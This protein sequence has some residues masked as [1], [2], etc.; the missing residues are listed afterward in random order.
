M[1]TSK[2]AR[3]FRSLCLGFCVLL[4]AVYAQSAAADPQ[5]ENISLY[6][7]LD[8]MERA[9]T[10]SGYS[11]AQM[12]KCLLPYISTVCD[13]W[14]SIPSLLR[15]EYRAMF[16]R[17]DDP[18]SWWYKEGLPRVLK[19]PHFVFHYTTTGPDA[20][21][22]RDISPHNGVPDFVEVCAESYEKSYRI[23]ISEMGYRAPYDDFWLDDNGGDE[24][25][26]V[27]MFS[28]PWLGFTM[29]EF[30]AAVQSTT[31]VAP[32]YF[33][34]N[35]RTYELLGD[36]EGKRYAETTCAH[37]FFHAVQFRYNYNMYRWYMETCSTWIERIVYDG[38]ELGETD[39]NNYYNNQLT[40]WFRYP[41]WSL[42]LFN[43][44]HEYGDVIW[45]IFLTERY[46]VDIVKDF[47]EDMSEG[48][49]RELANFYDVFE[50]RGTTLGV[51]FKEF[52]LWNYFTRD[53]HDDRFYSHGAEYPQVSIH[54]DNVHQQYPVRVDLDSEQSPEEL[55]SR[56]IR[57]LPEPG[58]DTLSIKVD[59]SDVPGGDDVQRLSIWGTRGWGAK[60]VIHRKGRSPKPDEIFLFQMSQEGQRNFA[61][62]GTEIQEVVLIL[63]N[64]HPDLDIQSVSYCAGQ[65]PQGRLSEPKLTS[66]DE[67]EIY[68]SWELLD[69]SGIKE[70]AVVRKRFAP[71][72]YDQDNSPIR[73]EEV[74]S[75]SD[76]DA[77]G[78]PDPNIDIAGRV[79]ATDTM[80]VDNPTYFDSVR[81]Y[82]AVVPLS[83]YGIMGTPAIAVSGI[84]PAAPPP[85][86]VIT[87]QSLAP[88]AWSVSMYASQ[89][90]N[91]MPEL[92]SVTPDGRRIRIKL[93]RADES[94]QL[95]QGEF[96][97]SPFPPT[98]IYTYIVSVKA[99]SGNNVH[100][101]ITE[102]GQFLYTGDSD[103]QEVIC[104]PNPFNPH[105]DGELKFYSSGFEISKIRIFAISGE[106]VIELSGDRWDGKNEGKETVAS[107]IYIYLAEG[108]GVE[109]TGK[110]AV[111]R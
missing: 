6:A 1:I 60:L 51:A 82:Y 64:L 25:Y 57:F 101:V 31:V 16:Q 103:K 50:S 10:H 92:V 7:A 70:V 32:M 35:S 47:F 110:I 44:W 38:D 28:G 84:T 78:I 65:Q 67:G 76:N 15:D 42:T 26:D 105:I 80:F 86:V 73:E 68:V 41:D 77:N 45:N 62:F 29:P 11:S 46:D 75:A 90:L 22:S 3:N 107:G 40:Y 18:Q 55:G 66:G 8:M 95:W 94:Y 30:P 17:P 98:G 34:M 49:Y 85:T 81:Y 54:P 12:E 111:T 20:V 4:V 104:A 108:D 88:G 74:Y 36:S 109:K 24:R 83:E 69:I 56:Y 87:T 33:G 2:E 43:G 9:R 93:S 61:G 19:T 23:E 89:P 97:V 52:T 96:N 39:G 37:E 5:S 58:Q 102:G 53:R 21:S 13:N 100:T 106:L 59:G 63:S 72:E 14:D 27:Y 71:Y 91:E 48:S 99:L 79:A